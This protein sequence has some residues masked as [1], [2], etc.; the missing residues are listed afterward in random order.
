MTVEKRLTPS[1][2]LKLSATR[3]LGSRVE[4]TQFGDLIRGYDLGHTLS[5]S[6]SWELGG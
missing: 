4:F 6:A 5:L 3:L 1:V 2:A